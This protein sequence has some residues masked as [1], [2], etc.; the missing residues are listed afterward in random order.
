M[1]FILYLGF[2]HEN[3]KNLK[4]ALD[5]FT[6]CLEMRCRLFTGGDHVAVRKVAENVDRIKQRMK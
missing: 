2:V 4:E 1:F 6:R 3:M 5:Y